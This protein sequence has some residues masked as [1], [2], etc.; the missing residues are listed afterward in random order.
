AVF[1]GG[2]NFR[3]E[4]DENYKANRSEMP[5]NLKLQMPYIKEMFE[6]LG[7]PIYQA[8]DVEADDVIGTLAKRSSKAGFDTFIISGDKDFRQIVAE[9]L[10][11]WDKMYNILYTPE[12]VK[13]VM[14]IEPKNV[15]AYLALMGD[16][17]DNVIGVEKVGKK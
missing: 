1:D 10:N 2:G 8:E 13:E 15:V 9:N 5:E 11:V 12:K 7:W 4:I 3:T 6:I 16:G 17:V 14:D